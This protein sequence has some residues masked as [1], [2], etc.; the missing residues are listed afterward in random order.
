V[1]RET[2]TWGVKNNVIWQFLQAVAGFRVLTVA[3]SLMP[4]THA[5]CT[6]TALFCFVACRRCANMER[7]SIPEDMPP[8]LQARLYAIDSWLSTTAKGGTWA[9]AAKLFDF[10]WNT[11][12][13]KDAGLE[14]KAPDH[15]V[16]YQVNK[17]YEKGSLRDVV[18]H[19]HP[20]KMPDAKV[21]EAAN[22]LAGGYD[23]PCCDDSTGVLRVWSEHR[24]FTSMAQATKWSPELYSM[25]QEYD[26]TPRYLLDRMHEVCKDLVYSALPIKEQLSPAQKKTRQGYA[27]WMLALYHADP[28]FLNKII[29]GD[30]T[31]I[32]L[33]RELSGKLKVYHFRGDH[34]EDGPEECKLLNKQNM[35]RLDVV[36][37]VSAVW[38]CCHVEFLTGTTDIRTDGRASDGM[39]HVWANRMAEGLGPYKVS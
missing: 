2:K 1:P 36:L 28:D 6:A 5:A 9:D 3:C 11:D 10:R 30:E 8:R 25:M 35:I 37:F 18:D 14:V 24:H 7:P 13:R 15:F 23:M 16:R 17:L 39:Q 27:Q 20:P 22:I 31:R 33:G 29:W 34:A 19:P 32:Y 26:V 21:K 38:G 12:A 4:H